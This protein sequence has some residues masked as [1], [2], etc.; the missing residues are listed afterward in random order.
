MR[1]SQGLLR[2][3]RIHAPHPLGGSLAAV[4]IV[5]V[6]LP[7][8][9]GSA[10]EFK[11]NSE[12]RQRSGNSDCNDELQRQAMGFSGGSHPFMHPINPQSTN[13]MTLNSRDPLPT[14]LC[15]ACA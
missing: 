14:R 3:L 1:P 11:G 7:A 8:H 10:R 13:P 6:A 2:I 4:Q 12:Q 9:S 15:A 5:P